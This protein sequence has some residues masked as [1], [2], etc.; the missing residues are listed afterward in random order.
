MTGVNWIDALLIVCMCIGA[1]AGGISFARNPDTYITFG[2][3]AFVAL[4][5]QLSKLVRPMS[6][7]D[8]K[9]LDKSRRLPGEWDNF[10]KRP[11]DK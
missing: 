9:K 10:K 1:I 7:E 4:L 11:R 2:K 3:A 5:P 6:P 8:Q